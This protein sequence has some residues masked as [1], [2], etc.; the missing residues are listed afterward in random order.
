LTAPARASPSRSLQQIT[1]VGRGPELPVRIPARRL[2]LGVY[3]V[4]GS[5]FA[6]AGDEKER[7]DPHHDDPDDQ[8]EFHIATVPPI[9]A[10][11]D[12]FRSAA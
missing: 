2:Q 8:Q 9:H 1:F 10:R 3:G 12:Q 11:R 7:D 4:Y 5:A 6:A